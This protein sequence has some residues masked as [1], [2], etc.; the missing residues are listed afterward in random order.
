MKAP[1]IPYN[2]PYSDNQRAWLSGFF[3]GMHSH[4]LQSAGS[5]N[6]ADARKLNILYG[7]QTGNSESVAEDV[8][9]AAKSH[10][11]VPLVKSMDEIDIAQLAQMEYVLIVTSTYGEG[12][13][14]DN[15]QILWEDVS[16]DD[17]PSMEQIKYSVLALGD[18]SYDQF[19]QAGI[20]MGSTPGSPRREQIIRAYRLRRRFRGTGGKLDQRSRP[21]NGGRRGHD[22]DYR[23][24][25]PARETDL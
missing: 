7:S 15:A 22:G 6:Q 13:M 25:G 12:E 1:Y 5:V 14:P 19:C 24:R 21:V 10:G 9:A 20:R 18:T 2:A 17:A 11:L 23:Y 8:A 16:A 3:A 4:M